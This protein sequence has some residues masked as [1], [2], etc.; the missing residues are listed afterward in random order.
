MGRHPRNLRFMVVTGIA[1]EDLERTEPLQIC[2][3]CKPK[4]HRYYQTGH[5]QSP[6]RHESEN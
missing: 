6:L 4:T 2:Q 1:I 3:S 5:D